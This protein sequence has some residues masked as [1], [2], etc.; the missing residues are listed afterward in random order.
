MVPGH[1]DVI[2]ENLLGVIEQGR[3]GLKETVKVPEDLSQNSIFWT[4]PGQGDQGVF[5]KS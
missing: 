1:N 5:F 4:N 3:W 2:P